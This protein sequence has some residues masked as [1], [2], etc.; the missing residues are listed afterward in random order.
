MTQKMKGTSIKVGSSEINFTNNPDE[1]SKEILSKIAD[2][3]ENPRV[4]LSYSYADSEFAKKL[5]RDLKSHGVD[6][7]LA[8][9]R[10]KIGDLISKKI[11]EAISTSQW[12]IVIM[13]DQSVNSEAVTTELKLALM[14]ENR[15]ERVLV[16]PVLY[17]GNMI[18]LTLENRAFADFRNDY[19]A[20]FEKLLSRIK[21]VSITKDTEYVE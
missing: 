7:W 19:E 3:Q 8:E 5:S 4:F 16:L 18:P 21:P 2:I 17:Q 12:I 20:G 9:E 10:I 13:S 11:D 15:R 6:V 1:T 14:E